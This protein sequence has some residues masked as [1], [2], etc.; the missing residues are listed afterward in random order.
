MP[1]I[2]ERK[3]YKVGGTFVVHVQRG[4]GEELRLHLDSH[5]V[6]SQVSPLAEAPFDRLELE[7]NIDAGVVQAILDQWER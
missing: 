1:E 7:G 5:G 6:A 2:K 3:L 4:R